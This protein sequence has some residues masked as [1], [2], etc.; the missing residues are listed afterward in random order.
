MV[1]ASDAVPEQLVVVD[2]HSGTVIENVDNIKYLV[3]TVTN[4]LQ[5]NTHISNDSTKANRTL[6]F[7]KRTFFSCPQNVKESAY[8]DMVR[9]ILEYGSVGL[10]PSYG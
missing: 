4:D 1:R 10:G 2:P 9:P 5:W 8:K 3:V 7:L 6:G